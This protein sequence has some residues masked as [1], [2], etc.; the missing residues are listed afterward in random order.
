MLARCKAYLLRLEDYVSSSHIYHKHRHMH[1]ISVQLP[2]GTY[3]C[4]LRPLKVGLVNGD[5][6]QDNEDDDN[7]S[8]WSPSNL[9]SFI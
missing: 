8:S 5:I 9:S 1:D 3:T 4:C 6:M 7:A 2:D